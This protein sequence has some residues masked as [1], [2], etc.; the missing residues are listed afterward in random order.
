MDTPKTLISET[1]LVKVIFYASSFDENSFFKFSTE[2]QTREEHWTKLGL[3][4]QAE[5]K[6][7]EQVKDSFCDKLIQN[8]PPGRCFIH[9]P[10]YPQIYPRNLSC[11]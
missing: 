8:C 7:H 1:P 3:Y 5:S 10:G 11:R 6:N 4:G 2:I 9:S